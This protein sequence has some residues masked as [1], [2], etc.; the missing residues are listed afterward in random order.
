MLCSWELRF[1]SWLTV[2]CVFNFH[3]SW[4]CDF[5]GMCRTHLFFSILSCSRLCMRRNLSYVPVLMIGTMFIYYLNECYSDCD[6][7]IQIYLFCGTVGVAVHWCRL[8]GGMFVGL[9]WH[10]LICSCVT[11]LHTSP[12]T[13]IHIYIH[14]SIYMYLWHMRQC[15]TG[16]CDPWSY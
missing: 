4:P 9:C 14:N 12:Q 11:S 15:T 7:P 10:I 16:R 5:Y 8:Y 1:S 2:Y 6:F 3:L 13:N